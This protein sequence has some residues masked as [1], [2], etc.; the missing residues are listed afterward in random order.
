MRGQNEKKNSDFGH[1]KS[2][3]IKPYNKKPAG[4]RPLTLYCGD[5]VSDLSA[6]RETDLLFAKHGH[7]MTV[8]PSS[9]VNYV[10]NLTC[11]LKDLITYCEREGIPFTVF[12]TFEDIHKTTKDIVYVYPL[13]LCL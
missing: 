1:D 6:A 2:L 12:Y 4:Q 5:G 7:G 8:P 10:Q 3:F 13:L 11:F 9:T